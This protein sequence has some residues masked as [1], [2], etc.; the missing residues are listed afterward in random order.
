MIVLYNNAVCT[1]FHVDPRY[2]ETIVILENFVKRMCERIYTAQRRMDIPLAA[3]I[4]QSYGRPAIKEAPAGG[5]VKSGHH[6]IAFNTA[7]HS[8][9]AFSKRGGPVL[10]MNNAT[11]A[12]IVKAVEEDKEDADSSSDESSYSFTL[13][14][15]KTY[16]G[17][18]AFE[19]KKTRKTSTVSKLSTMRS[20]EDVK[21]SC[22]VEWNVCTWSTQ[23][24]REFLH[25][26]YPLEVMRN[27][28]RTNTKPALSKT[29]LR[30]VFTP[31]HYCRYKEFSSMENTTA[32]SVA[33]EKSVKEGKKWVG[34]KD[35]RLVFPSKPKGDVR[36][37][38]NLE[39]LTPVSHHKFRESSRGSLWRL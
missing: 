19:R 11:T 22:K 7:K 18:R 2:H 33:T 38:L 4:F 34:E 36:P 27:R 28:P 29:S 13:T 5:E 1:Q 26:G 32:G 6:S 17:Y 39:P 25:P 12:T 8:G 31:F 16:A 15:K 21:N 14:A 37:P 30:F 23:E 35:F 9:Y 20:E 24:V 3:A 10:V